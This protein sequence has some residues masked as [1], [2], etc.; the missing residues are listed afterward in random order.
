M[1]SWLNIFVVLLSSIASKRLMNMPIKH[2]VL[3]STCA[4]VIEN[5]TVAS[6][7]IRSMHAL[8]YS[9]I[10]FFRPNAIPGRMTRIRF[11]VICAIVWKYYINNH[12]WDISQML[13]N[14]GHLQSFSRYFEEQAIITFEAKKN[15]LLFQM[16]NIHQCFF[17][18]LNR[19]CSFWLYF[20]L[21][22]LKKIR[23][24]LYFS[25]FTN[26]PYGKWNI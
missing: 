23:N 3:K 13:S 14:C 24:I 12:S 2:F 8:V 6:E 7:L 5:R 22:W 1:V 15:L 16:A 11:D 20:F 25:P 19:G 17:I 9:L 21:I 26:R 10:L 4:T 18:L